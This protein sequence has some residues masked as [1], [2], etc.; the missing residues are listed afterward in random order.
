[1]IGLYNFRKI[2]FYKSRILQTIK[3]CFERVFRTLEIK[4]M[5]NYRKFGKKVERKE[6]SDF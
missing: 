6:K 4:N 5:E 1:M 3:D 2:D